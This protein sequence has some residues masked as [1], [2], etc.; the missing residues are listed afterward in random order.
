MLMQIFCRT[1]WLSHVTARAPAASTANI[2]DNTSGWLSTQQGGAFDIFSLLL[3]ALYA[4]P[5]VSFMENVNVYFCS[6]F[7]A[8]VLSTSALKIRSCKVLKN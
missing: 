6:E 8:V 2:Q 5:C 7:S 3:F 1:D 4:L